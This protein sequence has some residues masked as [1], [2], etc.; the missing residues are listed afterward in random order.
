MTIKALNY[1]SHGTSP[2]ESTKYG[3]GDVFN[4]SEKEEQRLVSVGVAEFF[5]VSVSSVTKTAGNEDSESNEIS[6]E[7]FNRLHDM[8]D[9]TFTKE[10]LIL[11]AEEVGVEL[12]T[13]DKKLKDNV[14][15]EIILQ[16]KDQ[17][18]LALAEDK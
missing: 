8:L 7:E 3:P 9:T 2:G 1:I 13:D 10:K 11:K 17:E 14:I 15:E 18:V 12:T 5:N 16:G 6:E 4:L